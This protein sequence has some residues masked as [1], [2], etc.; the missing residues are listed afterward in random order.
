MRDV[1]E[2]AMISSHNETKEEPAVPP[3][4]LHPFV[5]NME[6]LAAHCY[7]AYAKSVN[8][9]YGMRMETDYHLL[10]API[11]K[12]WLAAAGVLYEAVL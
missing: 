9:S 5:K 1:D 12:G 10:P 4:S 11:Q 7:T 3:A 2:N 8:E 6:D